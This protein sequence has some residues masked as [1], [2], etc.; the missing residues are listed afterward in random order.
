MKRLATISALT[1]MLFSMNPAAQA[2]EIEPSET[3]PE[4]T[5]FEGDVRL[6]C[7]AILCLSSGT[8]PGACSPSL[9]RYFSI[10]YKKLSDTLRGRLD[11]LNLC[12]AANYD[13]NMRNLV[14]AISRGAGRCDTA[15]LNSQLRVWNGSDEP[16]YVSNQMPSYCTQYHGNSYTDL[17]LPKYVG[18]PERGGY[19]V[20]AANYEKALAEYNK[21]IAAEDRNN[22]NNHYNRFN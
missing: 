17:V 8:Q 5:L 13:S 2:Q 14:N 15:S 1:A 20:D 18:T 4:A 22:Q 6:A 12:P 21:R 16:T 11:F 7:E 9:D 19:W 3:S 10:V